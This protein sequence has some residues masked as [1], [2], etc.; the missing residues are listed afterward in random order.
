MNKFFDETSKNKRKVVEKK[1]FF[2]IE[3]FLCIFF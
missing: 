1:R 3:V 2:N